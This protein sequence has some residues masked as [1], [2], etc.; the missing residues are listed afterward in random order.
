MDSAAVDWVARRQRREGEPCA[1]Q[2]DGSGGEVLAAVFG[3]PRR[4]RAHQGESTLASTPV[5]RP[6]EDTRPPSPVSPDRHPELAYTYPHLEDIVVRGLMARPEGE[7]LDQVCDV[8]VALETAG[9]VEV[10]GCDVGPTRSQNAHPA[11]RLVP[12]M[13]KSS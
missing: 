7:V 8:I 5:R 12:L 13:E 10:S 4:G 6:D 1:D 3:G 9:V 2:R 11:R